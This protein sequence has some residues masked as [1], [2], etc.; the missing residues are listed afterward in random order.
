MS[1]GAP[2][3]TQVN[4]CW[5]SLHR[6]IVVQEGKLRADAQLLLDKELVV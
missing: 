1:E 5:K 4:S 3:S 6:L 2:I